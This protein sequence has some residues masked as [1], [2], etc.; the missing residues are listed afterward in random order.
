MVPIIK[1]GRHRGLGGK[2]K[3]GF[4]MGKPGLGNEASKLIANKELRPPTNRHVSEFRSRSS[5][6]SKSY[7]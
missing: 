7:R 4:E 6:L 1:M 3:T 5:T 2:A